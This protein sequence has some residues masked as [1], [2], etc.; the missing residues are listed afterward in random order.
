M[1]VKIKVVSDVITMR[2]NIK[3]LTFQIEEEVY[4]IRFIAF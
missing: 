1:Y 2:G 3:Y 4:Y